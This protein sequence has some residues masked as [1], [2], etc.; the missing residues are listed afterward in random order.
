MKL[1]EFSF[2]KVL[3]FLRTDTIGGINFRRLSNDV[4]SSSS[5]PM[6]DRLL[7]SF[8]I[9][10]ISASFSIEMFLF[11]IQEENDRHCVRSRASSNS[12]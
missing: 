1:S 5:L 10:S 3:N 7:H 6:E 12:L 8:N 2:P 4:I 11:S 9:F